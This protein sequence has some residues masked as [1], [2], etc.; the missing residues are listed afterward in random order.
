MFEMT[1]SQVGHCGG[2]VLGVEKLEVIE[3][4]GQ[5]HGTDTDGGDRDM[6]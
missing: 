5:S 1:E 3:I 6:G 4:G 2:E